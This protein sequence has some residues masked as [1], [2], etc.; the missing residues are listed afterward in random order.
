VL[1]QPP[2]KRKP[3][4]SILNSGYRKS[5][6]NLRRVGGGWFSITVITIQAGAVDRRL[7]RSRGSRFDLPESDLMRTHAVALRAEM[8]I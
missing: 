7:G 3:R 5:G 8:E 6:L 4:R 2:G 1:T